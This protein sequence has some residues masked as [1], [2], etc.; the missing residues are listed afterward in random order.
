MLD[1]PPRAS[2]RAQTL[3]RAAADSVLVAR[4]TVTA[5]QVA[6]MRALTAQADK[7]FASFFW[8][9]SKPRILRQDHSDRAERRMDPAQMRRKAYKA[10]SRSCPASTSYLVRRQRSLCKPLWPL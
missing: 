7:I 10:P 5:A 3:V 1:S 4:G 9:T 2:S 8:R 6:R